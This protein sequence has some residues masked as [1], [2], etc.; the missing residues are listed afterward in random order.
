[1]NE[2]IV[3]ITG[4]GS[5]IGRALAL[6][7]GKL[8]AKL[9][10]N[11]YQ[12]TGLEETKALLNEMGREEVLLSVF[13]VSDRKAMEAFATQVKASWGN[14]D[15]VINNAGIAGASLPAYHM[16]ETAY[17]RVM[18]I[19]F[20][21]VLNGCQ[22]FLPQLVEKNAGA[23]INLSSVFGLIGMPNNS[24]YCASKFAVRGY[25][26]AL[27]VEFQ[28]S[29]ISIHCVHPGGIATNIAKDT[30]NR[31]VAEK[32][33]TTPPEDLARFIIRSVQRKKPKIVYGRDSR[34]V[35]FL[36]NLVPQSITN[37]LLWQQA[38]RL[39]DLETYRAFLQPLKRNQ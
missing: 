37:R 4:A 14:A 18:D 17:R 12:E 11:D 7:Y 16:P 35:W 20:F 5:G 29:P 36:S 27:A 33:L 19:N 24:D 30:P 21:G 28:Q 34:K 25:T 22:A 38:K 23:I 2:P 13:D 1:M 8:G 31:R 26:E 9:A 15:V 39:L 3:V 10:L 32:L 6:E